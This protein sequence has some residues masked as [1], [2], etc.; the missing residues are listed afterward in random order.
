MQK[1]DS[2][3]EL[4]HNV[5]LARWKM[6]YS[7]RIIWWAAI[8]SSLV[9]ISCKTFE[10]Y[11]TSNAAASTPVKT[12]TVGPYTTTTTTTTVSEHKDEPSLI[13]LIF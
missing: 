9:R 5:Q 7:V 12:T 2:H 6:L 1:L 13:D 4:K 3:G 11:H 8:I 10:A